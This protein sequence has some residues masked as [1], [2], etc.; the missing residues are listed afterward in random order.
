MLR[1]LEAFL[2]YITLIAVRFYLLT[3][4]QGQTSMLKDITAS[5]IQGS[6]QRHTWS[7][8]PTSGRWSKR[9]KFADDTYLLIPASNADS[10]S[11]ELKN[12]E[13]RARANNLTL[14]N[15]K[16]KET[17]VVD[18]KRRRHAE[19]ATPPEMPVT[20]RVTSLTVLGVT[21]M[22]KWSVCVGTCTW[23]HQFVRANSVCVESASRT[24]SEWRRCTGHLQVSHP[25]QA[26]IRF[27]RLV[28]IHV[29]VQSRTH[30]RFHAS[31]QAERFLSTG[32]RV[33]RRPMWDS[34]WQTFQ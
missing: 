18:R 5:I 31:S 13:T 27:E 19:I 17:I 32:H 21:V 10:R 34:R 9:S 6:G 30:W 7:M 14:N 1:D 15:C 26:T 20:A 8:Q 25:R 33:I 24:W 2:R 16:T 29:G 12:A 28:G 22:D 4:C 3:Y 23:H 11:I